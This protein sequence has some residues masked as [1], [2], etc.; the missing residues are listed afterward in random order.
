MEVTDA[1]VFEALS[2]KTRTTVAMK[3]LGEAKQRAEELEAQVKVAF[4]DLHRAMQQAEQSGIAA[5]VTLGYPLGVAWD[6]WR[7]DLENKIAVKDEAAELA[8][9]RGEM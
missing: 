4:A 1:G 3:S 6:S 2:G 8:R 9:I 5:K 7:R